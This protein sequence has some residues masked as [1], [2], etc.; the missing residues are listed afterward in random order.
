MPQQVRS[1]PAVLEAYL[2]AGITGVTGG[3]EAG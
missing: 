1:D 2:G 3:G